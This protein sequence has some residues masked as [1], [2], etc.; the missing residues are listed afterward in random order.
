[1]LFFGFNTI[2]TITGFYALTAV[3]MNTTHRAADDVVLIRVPSDVPHTCIMAG[4]SG[5]HGARQYVINCTHTYN[6]RNAAGCRFVLS[7]SYAG[8]TGLIQDAETSQSIQTLSH[9]DTH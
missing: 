5:D 7:I 9:G 1:M 6:S 2:V 8:L 4:Q 3:C